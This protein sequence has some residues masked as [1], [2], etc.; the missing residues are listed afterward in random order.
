VADGWGGKRR[1]A[2]RKVSLV[3]EIREKA[4]TDAGGDAEYALGLIVS[5]MRDPVLPPLFR[6][7]C[8]ELVMDRVW[9]RSVQPNVNEN[10]GKVIVEWVY[11]N[12]Q[13]TGDTPGATCE[14]A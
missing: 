6:K 11:G 12:D 14:T 1:G 9:G 10:R 7:A 5:Y 3:T 13:A 2:G 8:A 4:I